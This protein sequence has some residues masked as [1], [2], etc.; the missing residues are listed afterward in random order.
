MARKPKLKIGAD[1]QWYVT[2]RMEKTVFGGTYKEASTKYNEWI[3]TVWAPSTRKRVQERERAAHQEAGAR[4][5]GLNLRKPPKLSKH[6]SG[7]WMVRYKRR[8]KYLGRDEYAPRIKYRDWLNHVWS[9][10]QVGKTYLNNL[11]IT[12][13]LPAT[14]AWIADDLREYVAWTYPPCVYFLLRDQQVVYVGSSNSLAKRV[15]DHI[16]EGMKF[17][18]VLWVPADERTY[19]TQEATFIRLLQP[20][21]NIRG[22]KTP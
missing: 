7:Q 15:I 6:A 12:R 8:T 18:R 3:S 22:K 20:I 19:R 21:D 11:I 5:A 9:H 16:D 17:E 13:S 2:S 14:L 10:D 1:G 4:R